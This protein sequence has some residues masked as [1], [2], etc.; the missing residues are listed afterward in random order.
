MFKETTV[1]LVAD[2]LSSETEEAREQW[3]NRFEV[4]EEKNLQIKNSISSKNDLSK[5]KMTGFINGS[6]L[7][8]Y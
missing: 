4:L 1:K 6:M 7:K 3:K 8:V 5:I 2:L